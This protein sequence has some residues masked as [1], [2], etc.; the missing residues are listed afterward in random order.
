MGGES[1]ARTPTRKYLDRQ[2]EIVRVASRILNRKGLKEMTLAD[3]ADRFGLVSTGIA[4]YFRSK[5]ELAAACFRRAIGEHSRLIL[6]A[7]QE[8][9]LEARLARL[10]ASYFEMLAA[11]ALGE[12]DDIAL[13]EDI[14]S[15]ND[16]A[17]EQDY[18]EMFRNLRRLLVAG[19]G[20][21]AQRAQ[22]N[23]RT[24]YLVQQLIWARYWLAKYEPGDYPRAAQRMVD[25]LL[26]GLDAD[27]RAWSPQAL[28]P[29]AAAGGVD[30]RRE[31][32][33]RAATQLI[34][35]Q[36]YRGASV[37]RI[38]ARLDV[39]KGSFYYRIDAK[40]DLI[41]ICYERTITALRRAQT[42]AEVLD[43]DGRQRLASALADL[44]GHQLD[45]RAPLLRIPTASVPDSIK[46]KILVGCDR[47]DVRFG[48]MLSDAIADGSVRAIDVQIAGHML[49]A[50][51]IAGAEL[52]GWL[53]GEADPH[54]AEA[55]V[56][57]AFEGLAD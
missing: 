9:T 45:G 46:Q 34:N 33:F 14:R 43:C 13:F 52:A 6:Q 31:M 25:L 37:D 22:R 2:D 49:T 53:S 54:T 28:P 29:N 15:L 32:F 48:S 23:A 11:I 12:A 56:R 5:E 50:T 24:H 57:S 8:R 38:V 44:V 26:H 1:R 20:D 40:D 7:A 27:R 36:G 55:F 3:V 42:E 4:Y 30:D 10:V 16:R 41:E 18:V 47:I 51:A 19:G 39:T 35:E 21:P 17:L